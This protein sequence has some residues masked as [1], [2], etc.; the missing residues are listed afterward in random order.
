VKRALSFAVALA[1]V[2]L[3]PH[4]ASA[5]D[6]HDKTIRIVVPFPPG[7]SADTLVRLL[8]QESTQST[9]QKYLIENRPGAGTIIGTESVARSAPDGTSLLV[10]SNSFVINAIVRASLPYDPLA[11]EPVCFLVDSPQVLVVNES[12][13]YRTL[14]DFVDAARAKPGELSYAAVGPATTQH[15]AG[16]M[17]KQVAGINLTYVPYAGGAPAMNALLGGHVTAVLGNYN[18]AMEQLRAGKLRP[19]AVAS[20]QRIAQLPDVPTFMESGYKDYETSAFFGVVA[21]AK[22]PVE[23][24]DKLAGLLTAALKAP[25]V[26]PKLVAQGLE[27]VGTCRDDFRAHIR[28][29]YEK[30]SRA[31]REA[32]IKAE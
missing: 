20:R 11:M 12:A 13:P 16:E 15:I 27:I 8:T 18:E 14:K 22:T 25:E 5:Q 19:L 32:N 24:I 21:P 6:L 3:A 2:V 1:C 31:I 28:R 29:Q 4:A 7:G 9:G 23:T 30:Y 17:F 10:M 26:T